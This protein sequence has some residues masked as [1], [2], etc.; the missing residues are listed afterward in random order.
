MKI[1]KTSN[2]FFKAL[3]LFEISILLLYPFSIIKAQVTQTLLNDEA[4]FKN[5]LMNDPLNSDMHYNLAKVYQQMR[6]TTKA[7]KYYHKAIF[8]NPNDSEAMLHLSGLQRN[9]G[10]FSNA[11]STINKCLSITPQNSQALN[12]LGLLHCDLA[13]YEKALLD[14]DNALKHLKGHEINHR[15]SIIYHKGILYLILKDYINVKHTL[16]QLKEV[17]TEMYNALHN[18]YSNSQ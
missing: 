9:S 17:D 2:L 10:N 4:Y 16:K 11:L 14:F 15:S 6:H 3:F 7:I 12:T 18:L 5:C 1:I 8:L 13:D